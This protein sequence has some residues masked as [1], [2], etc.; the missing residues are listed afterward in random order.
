MDLVQGLFLASSG[1]SVKLIDLITLSIILMSC[2]GLHT[3]QLEAFVEVARL[4]S[5]SKAAKALHITQSALSQRIINLESELETALL[6]RDP[7]GLKLTDEGRDLLRYC[8]CKDALEVEFLAKLKGTNAL[9]KIRIGGFS[10]VMRS[11]VL[12]SIAELTSEIGTVGVEFF[13]REVRELMP[14]LASNQVDFIITTE[15][16]DKSEIISHALGSEINVLVKP[17]SGDYRSRI[18]LDHDIHDST[19]FD[20]FKLQK[21]KSDKFE[22]FYLDEVY[23]II[24]GVANGMGEAVLPMHLVQNDRR[25]QIISGLK[26]LR[27][28]IYL[29]YYKLPFYS[30]T[31]KKIL[32]CMLTKI[33]KILNLAK[34]SRS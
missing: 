28:P 1:L 29:Q 3:A 13:C 32:E 27:I 19:T 30:E 20:F 34:E 24:D 17:K 21:K 31:H 33:P 4:S 22:R 25:L 10:S 2:M 16:S 5:F 9:G 6:I 7:A 15:P 12:P 8:R 11:L 18:I 23:T 14:I 26:P